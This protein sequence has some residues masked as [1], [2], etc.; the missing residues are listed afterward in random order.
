MVGQDFSG[1][2]AKMT[3]FKVQQLAKDKAFESEVGA[4]RDRFR[5]LAATTIIA[6]AIEADLQNM[7]LRDKMLEAQKIMKSGHISVASLNR[8]VAEFYKNG[9][10][11][12]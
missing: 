2:R 6:K 1:Y 11:L 7:A 9:L 8:P 5:V 10:L 12:L 3:E 4:L